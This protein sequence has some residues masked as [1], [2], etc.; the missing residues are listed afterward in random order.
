MKNGAC[1]ANRLPS[2]VV[3]ALAV[4]PI[5]GLVV[6]YLWPFTTLLARAING[7]TVADTLSRGAT[8][9]IAWFTLWQA[10]VST[11]IT[12]LV[13]LAPAYIVARFEF[14]G[15]QLL[16]GVLTAIFVLPT[17]VM[18]AA[19]LAL[20]PDSLDRT[21]WAVIAAHVVFNLAVMVRIV[22][23]F[24][25]HLPIDMESAAATLGASRWR[26]FVDISLPLLRP[27][28]SAAGAIIFLFTFTSFG[29]IR[30]LGS[31]GTRTLE[32]EVWRRA[33]QLGDISGAAVLSVLQLAVLAVVVGWSTRAQRQHARAVDLRPEQDRRRT[34]SPGERRFVTLVAVGTAALCIAPLAAMAIRSF[35]S[36]SGWSTTAWT[37]LGKAEVRPGI[38]L[39]IDPVGALVNSIQNA[40][41]A[42]SFAVLLGAVASLAIAA[43]GRGG[44]LLDVGLML[45]IGTSA[46][47][48]G[49][50][51][52][53]TFDT[54]PFDWRAEWWLVPVGHALVALPF[55]VRTTVGVLRSVDPSLQDAAATLGASPTRAW[56]N[57]VVPFLW[58]PLAVGAALAAAISLGEFGATSFLSRSGGE[59]LPIA[60]DEL[61][62]R[63]GSLLQAQGYALATILAVTTVSLIVGVSRIHDMTGLAHQ[64]S[65]S[66]TVD[67]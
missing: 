5:A 26:I 46:V 24:W 65:G 32:I 40:A 31:A 28:L 43:A 48:I 15:R 8:W 22:G 47:T 54:P 34:K 17:V 20:L 10:V 52:L 63:T 18:G 7:S 53:I 23:A 14:P 19:F 13:G 11:A 33:T 51:M 38:R 30:I 29:V 58:R 45:P 55:V 64:R 49:F 61:L 25:E 39:G 42:S 37:T 3:A 62:G 9:D 6:F 12:M 35:R 57:V 2:R 50:G 60:I 36:A 56:W 41:W 44:R 66:E 67:R 16:V 27:S 4:G 21:V 1:A 59:T